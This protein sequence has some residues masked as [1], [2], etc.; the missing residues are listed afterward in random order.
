MLYERCMM[1]SYEMR[2][3]LYECCM[4]YC[5]LLKLCAVLQGILAQDTF[6]RS[7]FACCLEIV[8]FSYNSQ[9][10][11]V[12]LATATAHATTGFT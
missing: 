6:H 1:Y 12:R 2:A 5:I 3:V 7:L 10:C 11:V 8:I 4:M 9:R